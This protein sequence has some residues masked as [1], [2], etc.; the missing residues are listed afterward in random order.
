MAMKT[1]STKVQPDS[2]MRPAP[3]KTKMGIQMAVHEQKIS[4]FL[5]LY[6]TGRSSNSGLGLSSPDVKHN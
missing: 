5:G 2:K 1:S 4:K 6:D 3:A